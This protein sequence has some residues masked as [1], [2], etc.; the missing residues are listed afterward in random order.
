[1][2]Q[3]LLLTVIP[4]HISADNCVTVAGPSAGMKCMLPFTFRGTTFN[5]CTKEHSLTGDPWCSTK[6]DDNGYHVG[7]G[8]YLLGPH[9]GY[10]SSDCPTEN[11]Q[12]MSTDYNEIG[13]SMA[14]ISLQTLRS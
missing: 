14:A 12:R 10:C 1:M 13:M 9:F 6:I 7:G 8:P 2:S 11:E 4:L 5:R 3:Y